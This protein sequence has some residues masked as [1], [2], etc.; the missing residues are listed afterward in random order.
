M[1]SLGPSFS[2]VQNVNGIV[3]RKIV[4]GLH[5]V[6]DQ[7]RIRARIAEN[8]RNNALMSRRLVPNI[9]F[10]NTF[11]KEPQPVR[12]V[13]VKFRILSAGILSA[14]SEAKRLK[15]WNLTRAQWL[16]FKEICDMTANGTVRVSVSDKGG[17]FVV[18]P[19]QLDSEITNLHL[20]DTTVYRRINEKDFHAQ[21]KR[22]NHV[23]MTVGKAAGLDDRFLSR[24]KLDNPSCPMFIA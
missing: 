4:G 9:P 1:L 18:I 14:Y 7:L 21:C 5:K 24:L 19:R 20:N 10:P 3:F 13:D 11:Y 16:G 12:E 17:E 8:T 15:R 23:W 2:F 22:L 6:R